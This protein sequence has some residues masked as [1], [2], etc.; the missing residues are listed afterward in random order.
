[1]TFLDVSGRI[2]HKQKIPEENVFT[3]IQKLSSGNYILHIAG[4]DVQKSLQFVKQ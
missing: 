4:N 2:V 3:N 1:M